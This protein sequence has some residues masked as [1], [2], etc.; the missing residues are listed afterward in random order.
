MHGGATARGLGLRSC[1]AS[2]LICRLFSFRNAFLHLALPT[3]P[4]SPTAYAVPAFSAPHSHYANNGNLC[5]TSLAGCRRAVA[6]SLC[7]FRRLHYQN[8][9]WDNIMDISMQPYLGK[10]GMDNLWHTIS[11]NSL[12]PH[13]I[14]SLSL[15]SNSHTPFSGPPSPFSL[16]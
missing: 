11:G 2:L 3:F 6:I 13:A 8:I 14:H 12:L 1:C 15:A 10:T 16:L 5:I 4:I 9:F 7:F